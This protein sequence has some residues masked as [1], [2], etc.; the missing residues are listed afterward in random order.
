MHPKQLGK[1]LLMNERNKIIILIGLIISS[2]SG[3]Y[4]YQGY[5]HYTRLVDRATQVA[6]DKIN[7]TIDSVQD[8]SYKPYSNRINNLL[9]TSP[10]II[11][12]FA[13]RDRELLYQRTLPK[14]NALVVENQFF[15]VMHFHLPNGASFLRMHN[16]SFFD[17]DL[18]EIRPMVAKVHQEK[19]TLMGYEIGRYGPFYR[20]V[21]PVFFKNSYIG[22]LEIGIR[23]D[24]LISILSA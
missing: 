7:S 8:F 11:A 21:H 5:S 9:A 14:Y 22:A 23:A 19:K 24:E 2:L 13:A 17:D 4:F 12:A 1:Q 20:V 16:P 10:D 6:E 18:T 15:Q 3:I